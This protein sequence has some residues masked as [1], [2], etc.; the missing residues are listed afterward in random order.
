MRVLSRL[1]RVAA[2]AVTAAVALAAAPMAAS[3]ATSG[4]AKVSAAANLPHSNYR[5][6]VLYVAQA[7]TANGVTPQVT[8]NGS[9]IDGSRTITICPVACGPLEQQFGTSYSFSPGIFTDCFQNMNG[10]AF[11]WWG[12]TNP[13]DANKMT[14]ANNLWVAGIGVSISAG[15]SI[16]AGVSISNN[17]I[18]F[19]ESAENT[20]QLSH[21]FSNASF[22]SSLGMTGPYENSRDSATFGTHTYTDFIN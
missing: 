17:T 2:L 8:G 3:A 1:T 5:S 20:F 14:L 10:G 15:A 12:G 7:G 22:C 13:F 16:G 11:A 4:P 21:S 18:F 9:S 19:T 6:P